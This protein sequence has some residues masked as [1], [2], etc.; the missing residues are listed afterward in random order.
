[1]LHVLRQRN[2][3]LLW[4]GQLISIIGDWVLFIALPYYVYNLTGS[5]LATGGMFIAETVPR[6]LLGSLAGVFVDRWDRKRTMIAADLSRAVVLLLLLTVRSVEWLWL[7]YVVAFTESAISQFFVPAKSA[8]IPRLVQERDLMAANSLD[9]L[10]DALTRLIGPSLG[11]ALMSFLGLSSVVLL[12]TGSYVISAMLILLITAPMDPAGER[13]TSSKGSVAAWAAVW[14]EWLEGLRLVKGQQLVAGLFA[15]TGI[16]M[17]A[18][19]IIN[20]LLVVFVKDVLGGGALEFGWLATA[21]GVGG[22][23]GGFVIG[24]VGQAVQPTRLTIVGVW[25]AGLIFLAMV[26]FP[27]L[28]LALGLTGLLGLPAMG[29]MI[30]A[31]TLLQATVADRYRGRVFGAYGTTNALLMLVG[32]GLAAALGD[33]LG[34][35]PVLDLAG[36]LFLVAGVVGLPML[37]QEEPRFL[38]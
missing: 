35:V 37:K 25:A 11:G 1:M 10:S 34:V 5:A 27:S 15:V 6:L 24:Q 2:F 19:G 16:A 33:A 28:L 9:A 32:M 12:D 36:G 17:I 4:F 30:S 26:N 29:Y 31:Q 22:L 38:D 20:V 13:V 18:Q 7:V 23:I 21:Q 3:S 8:V 14:Q